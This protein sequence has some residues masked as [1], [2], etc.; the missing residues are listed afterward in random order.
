M[1]IQDI[2]VDASSAST[3]TFRLIITCPLSWGLWSFTAVFRQITLF[4]KDCVRVIPALSRIALRLLEA[5]LLYFVSP[6]LV[7]VF[8]VYPLKKLQLFWGTTTRTRAQ[9]APRPAPGFE[10]DHRD[11]LREAVIQ[12]LLRQRLAEARAEEEERRSRRDTG[13][14]RSRRQNRRGRM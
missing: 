1:A 11:M 13:G 8:W 2:I 9:T 5:Y 4:F 12:E 10:F 6:V 7:A 14:R 3:S